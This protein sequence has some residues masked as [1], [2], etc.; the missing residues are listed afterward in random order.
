MERLIKFLLRRLNKRYIQRLQS[1]ER[2]ALERFQK[3][4]DFLN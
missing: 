3:E 1:A 2:Q 4:R